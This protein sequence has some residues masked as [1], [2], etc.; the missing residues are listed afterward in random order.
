MS[1]PSRTLVIDTSVLINFIVVERLDLL[2]ALP[3]TVCVVTDHVRGEVTD[4]Y[5]EQVDLLFDAL[6]RGF[7]AILRV[8]SVEELQ[9]FA[10][11]ESTGLGAGERS[12]FAAALHRLY[13]VAID[14]RRAIKIASQTLECISIIRTETIVRELIAGGIVSVAEADSIKDRWESRNRFKLPFA[15]FGDPP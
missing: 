12:A 2:A 14:D 9:T 8:D 3:G 5:P 11:L 6:E 4:D 13:M 15:S 10:A 1:D 7:L